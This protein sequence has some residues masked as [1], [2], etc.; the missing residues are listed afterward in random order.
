MSR[1]LTWDW[2]QSKVV[3]TPGRFDTPCWNWTGK[4]DKTG[5]PNYAWFGRS[6]LIEVH[7]AFTGPVPEGHQVHHRC[8]NPLCLNPQHLQA[9]SR[10]QN[11]RE[12]WNRRH[13]MQMVRRRLRVSSWLHDQVGGA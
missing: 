6:L 2:L 1:I 9:I 13:G 5:Y 4:L 7:E 11:W 10:S 8:I 12:A 3:E